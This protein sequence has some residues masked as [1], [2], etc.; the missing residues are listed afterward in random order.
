MR[1]MS[2]NRSDVFG[3]I[4]REHRWGG[5]SVS[6]PG[7]ALHVTARLR[8]WLPEAFARY[9]IETLIDAPCGDGIWIEGLLPQLKRYYGI[10]IVPD[11]VE[12][13][14]ERNA[15]EHVS[16]Q[17]GDLVE[18]KLP[19]ADAIFCRDCLVHLSLVDGRHAL[20]NMKQSGARYLIATTFPHWDNVEHKKTGAWRP[21]NLEKEPFTLGRPLEIFYERLPNRD[22]KYN[23]KAMGVWSFKN[24]I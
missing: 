3:T 1:N 20:Q 6:G 16:Y 13:A 10:D 11:L 8:E 19:Q 12:Q 22:D 15:S 24:M 9:K 17:I 14:A 18:T 21:L 2:I 4:Y 23:N 5:T 7:S